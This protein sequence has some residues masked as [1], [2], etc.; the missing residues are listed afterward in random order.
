MAFSVLLTLLLASSSV[1][2]IPTAQTGLSDETVAKV[3]ANLQQIAIHRY[4]DQNG[5]IALALMAG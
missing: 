5:I 3:K 2:A 4:G 1:L